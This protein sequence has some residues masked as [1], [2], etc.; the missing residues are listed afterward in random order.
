M[1]YLNSMSSTYK[2]VCSTFVRTLAHHCMLNNSHAVGLLQ[3]TPRYSPW[4]R[5]RYMLHARRTRTRRTS[6]QGGG[7][8]PAAAT[9]SLGEPFRFAAVPVIPAAPPASAQ[10]G[11]REVEAEL[12]PVLE[13]STAA[14]PAGFSQAPH[15]T[16]QVQKDGHF[17]SAAC[18]SSSTPPQRS[19][20]FQFWPPWC[21]LASGIRVLHRLVFGSPRSSSVAAAT[22]TAS[23]INA[24]HSTAATAAAHLPTEY[25]IT[26]PC[27][28][29]RSHPASFRL[30]IPTELG[31]SAE[32]SPVGAAG[33]NPAMPVVDRQHPQLSRRWQQ[34]EA[35]RATRQRRRRQQQ[36]A[37]DSD[38]MYID[39]CD[40]VNAASAA[41]DDK[42]SD[43]GSPDAAAAT[44]AP[45]WQSSFPQVP[46]S[47]V[48]TAGI[49][50]SAGAAHS[51]SAVAATN[52]PTSRP[53]QPV[54]KRGRVEAVNAESSSSSLAAAAPAPAVTTPAAVSGSSTGPSSSAAAGAPTN[55]LH[56]PVRYN[57]S[58]PVSAAPHVSGWQEL[59][60]AVGLPERRT[61][62]VA[63]RLNVGARPAASA[64]AA[65]HGAA[66]ATH[67]QQQQ[68]QAASE[69]GD[70]NGSSS[71]SDS[72]SDLP[73][74]A[75]VGDMPL[76]V[77]PH[78][79]SH[80]SASPVPSLCSESSED[81]R[82]LLAAVDSAFGHST[83]DPS[84]LVGQVGPE[85]G[86]EFRELVSMPAEQH[87]A[88]AA[89]NTRTQQGP[90][91]GLG[92]NASIPNASGLDP[93]PGSSPP[94]LL[95]DPESSVDGSGS[96]SDDS[97]PALEVSQDDSSGS[98]PYSEDDHTS[99]ASGSG[100]SDHSS[101]DGSDGLATDCASSDSDSNGSMPHL[102]A[103]SEDE[104][105]TAGQVGTR[106]TAATAPREAATVSRGSSRQQ[107]VQNASISSH[108][109]S[110]RGQS[111]SSGLRA[112]FLGG[113]LE[114]TTWT[115]EPRTQQQQRSTSSRPT[116]GLRGSQRTGDLAAELSP[117]LQMLHL[118]AMTYA[119]LGG[120]TDNEDSEL[121]EDEDEDGV[122][123]DDDDDDD[124]EGA[125]S[126]GSE[127][128]WETAS[129]QSSNAIRPAQHHST[130][131]NTRA[132]GSVADVTMGEH[133]PNT[134]RDGHSENAAAAVPFGRPRSNAFVV[135]SS[136]G[137]ELQPDAGTMVRDAAA[138]TPS[139]KGLP[140]LERP[141]A[142][143]LLKPS[144]VS[145]D[146]KTAL[147]SENLLVV[148]A[149]E[150]ARKRTA[151][152]LQDAAYTRQL[153]QNLP[154]VDISNPGIE[155]V[156]KMLESRIYTLAL[157]ATKSRDG[158]RLIPHEE[159]AFTQN[160]ER[161]RIMLSRWRTS[162]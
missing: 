37:E 141:K 65:A 128:G 24:G 130:L 107:G 34:R 22:A 57:T 23:I 60:P 66:G 6:A 41:S 101:Q 9:A 84:C 81:E 15:N 95:D 103:D 55:S 26:A 98:E 134:R 127:G 52:H 72:R 146:S 36:P 40:P 39:T 46:G 157:A 153:L 25:P 136:I 61:T 10:A 2:P 133:G 154:G 63:T 58:W 91:G 13:A 162:H 97:I 131:A 148:S 70:G 48:W 32:A 135:P 82:C 122:D 86:S 68:Q 102:E 144:A 118:S 18:S 79:V 64:A 4:A 129:N 67:K 113:R 75:T 1:K 114:Q 109:G 85:H 152:L 145:S 62:A 155:S 147:S 80:T 50:S 53:S 42:S 93:Q 11:C 8:T 142:T 106:S 49:Q 119:A 150:A 160:L 38:N 94:P 83:A 161:S 137:R 47:S 138:A 54:S 149:A 90:A 121:D 59:T 73:N 120:G 104:S 126:E 117:F 112:G 27:T 56:T 143:K 88:E 7:S 87:S 74:G 28:A 158:K 19:S 20:S 125:S 51:P 29:A 16:T 92:S 5:G 31:P 3:A 111:H 21:L 159:Y 100:D 123:D 44:T 96:D 12:A 116:D 77:E 17:E 156:L 35:A 14:A 140:V 33:T 78:T 132:A 139:V 89:S 71:D 115:T 45:A 110:D 43:N 76:S 30:T 99:E 108:R 124:S 151:R 105:A 69:G